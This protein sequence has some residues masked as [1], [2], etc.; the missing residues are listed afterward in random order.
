[1][2]MIT[3]ASNIDWNDKEANSNP[4]FHRI[5]HPGQSGDGLTLNPLLVNILDDDLLDGLPITN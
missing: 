3:L 1:M 2:A 5:C 4:Q